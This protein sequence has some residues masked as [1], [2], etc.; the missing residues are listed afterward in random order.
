MKVIKNQTAFHLVNRFV[1]LVALDYTRADVIALADLSQKAFTAK[2]R[3]QVKLDEHFENAILANGC[4]NA[5]FQSIETLI[6]LAND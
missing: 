5:V 4:I 1:E 3:S 6:K 2:A